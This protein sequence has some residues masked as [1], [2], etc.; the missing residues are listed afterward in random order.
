MGRLRPR[1]KGDEQGGIKRSPSD[2]HA[3][4]GAEL[5]VIEEPAAP[6][7]GEAAALEKLTTPVEPEQ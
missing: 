5:D 6:I 1:F 4:V 3:A 7:A 2:L